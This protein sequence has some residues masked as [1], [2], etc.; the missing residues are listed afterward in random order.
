MDAEALE[1]LRQSGFRI[2]REGAF[3]HEGQPVRHEGLRRALFGW[4]DRLPD[5]RTILRLD[6]QRFAY[7]DVD[8]T[9]LVA[10]GARVAGD[11]VFLALSDGAE[12]R[13]DP[14]TLSVDAAGIMRCWVRAARIE[15]RLSTSAAIVLAELIDERSGGPVLV[16]GDGAFPLGQRR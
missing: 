2:D 9:P 4:L 8:D 7:V 5:G 15:A 14:R 16:L 3:Q 1:R 13:L 10:Q 11:S 12:E 6:A